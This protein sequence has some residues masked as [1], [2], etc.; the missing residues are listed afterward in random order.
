[1]KI[2]K[3][4]I[5]FSIIFLAIF[6]ISTTFSDDF[7]VTKNLEIF[8]DIFREVNTFYADDVDAE[9]MMESGLNAMLKNMDPY[10]VYIPAEE[11]AAFQ[12]SISGKYAGIGAIVYTF[13]DTILISEVYE[14]SPAFKGGLKAGD[15]IYAIEGKKL[16]D[17]SDSDRSLLLRGLVGSKLAVE[18]YRPSKG[19]VNLTLTREEILVNNVPFYDIV[20]NDIGYIVLS[21]FTENAGKN[22][23]QALSELSRRTKL[24]GVILDLR[25]N[26]GGLL[27]EAVNVVNIFVPKATVVVSTKS[28]NRENQNNYQTLNNPFDKNIPLVVLV[29]ESSASASEIVAGAIQD[30]DRG[31]II[32]RKTYGKGLVQNTK[33]LPYNAKIKLTTSRYYTPSGRC[34]QSSNYQSGKAVAIADSLFEKFKTRNGRIVLDGGGVIPDVN[35]TN[36][37]L[38]TIVKELKD[39]RHIFNFGVSY[40]QKNTL[41]TPESFTLNEGVFNDFIR[42]LEVSGFSGSNQFE[43]ALSDF[44]SKLDSEN[45]K[46]TL[47]TELTEMKDFIKKEKLSKL[48][49]YKNEILFEIQKNIAEQAFLKRGSILNTLKIDETINKGIQVLNASEQYRSILGL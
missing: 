12:S 19:K 28:K 7:E 20:S 5:Y 24:K 41:S 10:T 11:V 31:V 15:K 30:L 26:S 39:Q 32:G 16:G 21:T 44:E 27:S 33:D 17:Y 4:S 34:I 47:S 48:S 29:D 13:K 45:L 23:Q 40:L 2:K 42:S 37:E 8:S 36:V 6:A 43:K 22:V 18:L 1:M 38:K 3:I 9:K 14:N 46:G 25:G 35:N 49:K